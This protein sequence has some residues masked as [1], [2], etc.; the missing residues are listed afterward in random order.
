MLIEHAGSVPNVDEK[1]YVAPNAVLSGDVTIGPNC[2]ILFGVVITADGGP[3][4][5][6][7]DCVVMENAVVRGTPK[8]PTRLGARVLVGP[9]AHLSGCTIED[10]AFL[11]TGATVLNGATVRTGAEVRVNAIVHVNSVVAPET[12]VPIGWIAVGRPAELF[13]PGE[14]NAIWEMQRNMDFPGTVF[15]VEREVR[16]GKSVSRYAR[17]LRDHHST[18]VVKD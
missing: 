2:S 8:H 17:S 15:G 14:H 1:S 16:I 4:E 13:P 3:V 7:P 5:V 18:D 9:H 10:D 12:V 6:G 11:A